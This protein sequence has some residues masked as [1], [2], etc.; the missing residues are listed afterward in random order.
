MSGKG[1][2]FGSL[3]LKIFLAIILNDLID[4]TGQVFMKKGLITSAAF[5]FDLHEIIFFISRNISSPLLWIG[6]FF[7]A[8]NFFLWIGILSQIDLSLAVPLGSASYVIVPLF[9]M[10]FLRE[11]INASQWAGIFLIIIGIFFLSRSTSSL[12]KPAVS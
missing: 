2:T 9:A 11:Q 4:S 12:E 5:P 6:I 10:I 1:R 8:V 7:Y 3:S